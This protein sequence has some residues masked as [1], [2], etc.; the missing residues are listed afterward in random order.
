MHPAPFVLVTNGMNKRLISGHRAGAARRAFTM[1]ELALTLTVIAIMAAMM[2]PKIGRVMQAQRIRRQTTIVAADLE[3][4]FTLAARYRKPMRL[5]CT[6]ASQTY[7]IADRT[8]GTVRLS[9]RLGADGDLGTLTLAFTTNP[10]IGVNGV[11]DI[12]P[13]G[14]SST[15]LTVTLTSGSSSRT[16]TLST[17]GLVRIP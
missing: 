8:G 5:S 16:V 14:V 2:V 12:F 9:R 4:A 6:C 13:S 1:I 17:A 3:Q 11:V 7:T 15:A 10:V